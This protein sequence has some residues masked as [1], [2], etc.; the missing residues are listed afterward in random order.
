MPKKTSLKLNQ[1]RKSHRHKSLMGLAVAASLSLAA[2]CS[3]NNSTSM[4]LDMAGGGGGEPDLALPIDPPPGSHRVTVTLAGTGTGTVTSQPAGINCSAAGTACAADFTD[5]TSVVL[6]ASGANNSAFTGWSGACAGQGAVCTLPVNADIMTTAKFGPQSCSPDG[7][8]W[9]APLPFGYDLNSVAA[10]AAND[11]W[12]V[13][14]A[15]AAVHYDGQNWTHIATNTTLDLTDVWARNTNDVWATAGAGTMLH[16]TGLG[17]GWVKVLTGFPNDVCTLVW[18][19]PNRVFVA[20]KFEFVLQ[21]DGTTWTK[22]GTGSRPDTP[23]TAMTG[24][25]NTDV[26]AFGSDNYIC[27]FVNAWSCVRPDI[28]AMPNYKS[29][30]GAFSVAANDI[31]EVTSQGYVSHSTNPAGAFFGFS[32]PLDTN[33]VAPTANGL[34][35][36]SSTSLFTNG[37]A[38]TLYRYDGTKWNA[39]PTGVMDVISM[40]DVHGTS[41]SDVWAVGPR[42]VIAHYNGTAASVNR[43][44]IFTGSNLTSVWAS[45]PN[46]AWFTTTAG[47]VVHYN[48]AAF[49]ESQPLVTGGGSSLKAVWGT[50]PDDIWAGGTDGLVPVMKHWNGTT[51]GPAPQPAGF[52]GYAV[53]SVYAASKTVAYAAG[54]PA[55]GV[56]KW[57]GT[58]WKVDTGL[59]GLTQPVTKVWGTS[60]SQVFAIEGNTTKLRLWNGAVWSVDNRISALLYSL[61]GSGATDIWAGSTQ[62]VYH[63]DGTTWG[64]K[65]M[66]PGSSGTINSVSSVSAT[67][68]WAV[69]ANGS[70]FHTTDGTT[71]KQIDTGVSTGASSKLNTFS[72]NANLTWLAGKSGILSIRK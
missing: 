38:A 7:V 4:D 21:F 66:I 58:S 67:N 61:G 19:T 44:N 9:E 35:G 41:N 40:V 23:F 5:G 8:C 51:W 60:D 17:T 50:A 15:G 43:G 34:W 3:N 69:D 18:G 31:W 53:D 26:W 71:W 11:V 6:T 1:S 55:V 14:N 36:T 16:Y 13:G 2:G 22:Q 45:G 32:N 59:T 39:N 10:L 65:I 48:G 57:D 52:T 29:S 20:T 24:T 25:S 42:G 72:V 46:D 54:D 63:F 64:T 37:P 27:H 30:S 28:G 56:E 12:A 70:V 49:T 47:T 62:S 68:A 33:K